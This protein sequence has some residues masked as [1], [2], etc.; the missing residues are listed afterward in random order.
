MSTVNVSIVRE[1]FE[2]HDFLIRQDRKFVS[3]SLRAEDD[4]DFYALNPT[5]ADTDKPLPFILSPDDLGSI[6][7]ALVVVK[8]WHSDVFSPAFLNNTPGLFRFLERK[9]FR[10]A[11]RTFSAQAGLVKILVIPALPQDRESRE[12]SISIFRTKGIDAVI[13]FGTMLTDLANR[14]EPNRYYTKSDLL[15]T[16]RL[17]KHYELL[18]DPQMELFKSRR[19]TRTATR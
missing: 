19:K 9:R 10:E 17:L 2:F 3:P 13:T 6:S 14:V 12:E 1:F 5:P 11:V 8:P 16:L 4:V 7:R 15:Q 18:R